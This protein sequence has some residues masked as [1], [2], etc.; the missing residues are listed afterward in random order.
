MPLITI[1]KKDKYIYGVW[2]I[3]ENLNSLLNQIRLNKNDENYLSQISNEQRK[4]QSIAAKI[5]LNQIS[6]KKIYIEYKENGAPFCAEYKNISISH[7]NIFSIALISDEIIGIDIQ[8]KKTNIKKLKSKFIN[9]RDYNKSFNEIEFLHHNW[10]SKEAIYKTLNNLKCSFKTN[11][12]IENQNTNFS[13]GFYVNDD[14]KI[15]FEINHEK[16]ENYFIS[17]AKKIL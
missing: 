1:K 2:R 5:T 6:D 11:I 17:I 7:S 3:T 16:F 9:K 12:Y 10:C 15:N 13:Q 8:H 4:K 14:K